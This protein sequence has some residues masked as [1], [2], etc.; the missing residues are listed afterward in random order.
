MR[1]LFPEK[2]VDAWIE[3]VVVEVVARTREA[4]CELLI[5]MIAGYEAQEIP[6]ECILRALPTSPYAW[7]GTCWCVM[8]MMMMMTTVEISMQKSLSLHYATVDRSTLVTSIS[9]DRL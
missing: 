8:M 5:E 1:V 9:L 6:M 4:T 3:V 7:S 2:S